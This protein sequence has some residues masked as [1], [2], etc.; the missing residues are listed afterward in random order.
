MNKAT[1]TRSALPRSFVTLALLV[2]LS[3][4]AK[5]PEP[6]PIA[7]GKLCESW[8]HKKIKKSDHLTEETASM[9][10]GDNKA[11]AEWNCEYGAD[12]AKS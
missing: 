7:I 4:C 12:R 8:R 3:G 1:R 10:E 2:L 11:R 6:A 5:T 9:I